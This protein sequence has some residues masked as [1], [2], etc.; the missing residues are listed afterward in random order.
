MRTLVW[1]AQDV[2]DVLMSLF[3]KDAEPYKV[4][5][6]PREHLGRVVADKVLAG[7]EQVGLAT[8]RCYSYWFREMLSLCVID[9]ANAEPG[10]EVEVVWGDPG[11]RQ[12]HIRATVARAPYKTD[13]RRADVRSL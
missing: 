8:S 13:N 9:V 12:K 7:G 5:E 4:I 1:N 10:T 11:T 2:G 3:R 6:W